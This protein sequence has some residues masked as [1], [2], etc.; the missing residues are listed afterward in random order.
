MKFWGNQPNLGVT[1]A[2]TAVKP[3]LKISTRAVSMLFALTNNNKAY[4]KITLL[5]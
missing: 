2:K 4:R 3:K 5:K 1:T